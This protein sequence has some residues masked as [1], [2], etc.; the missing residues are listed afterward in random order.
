MSFM[1]EVWETGCLVDR[2]EY[3]K[4]VT[5]S[6]SGA[7]ARRHGCLKKREIG[8]L[9]TS[10]ELHAGV[11]SVEAVFME[12]FLFTREH[13]KEC[14]VDAKSTSSSLPIDPVDK[15]RCVGE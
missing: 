5:E 11:S 3:E 9:E 8:D 15:I 12:G 4:A 2:G 7:Y 13:L 14:V 10:P 6:F 1:S